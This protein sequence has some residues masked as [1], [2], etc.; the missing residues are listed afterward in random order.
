MPRSAVPRDKVSN[1]PTR[2]SEPLALERQASLWVSAGVVAHTLWTSAAPPMTYQLYAE[3]WH[4]THTVTTGIFAIYPIVVVT[5]LIIFGDISDYIGRRTTMLLG[6]GASLAGVFLFAVAPAGRA[7]MGVG[8]GMTAGPST[9]AVLEFST[10]GQAKRASSI[11][12]AAQ[13]FGLAA[14]LLLGGGLTQYAPWPTR[15]SFWALFALIA[16]LFAA[17]WFLP[18]HARGQTSNRWRPKRPSMPPV[19]GRHSR[20]HRSR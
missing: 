1:R 8:V 14:A 12:A 9:A 19:C 20:L 3:E 4:L 6:L 11:A 5:V 15:L 7:L 2:R 13:A 17:T 10:E 18:R 16:L